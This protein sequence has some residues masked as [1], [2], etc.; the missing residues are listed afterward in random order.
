MPA[1][2]TTYPRRLLRATIL[3]RSAARTSPFAR[4]TRKC[5][6]RPRVVATVCASPVRSRTPRMSACTCLHS[7]PSRPLGHRP[8]FSG[9]SRRGKLISA[10]HTATTL[11]TCPKAAAHGL[12]SG[13][14]VSRE[15]CRSADLLELISHSGSN[16]PNNGEI[17]I[18]EGAL[19]LYPL[20]IRL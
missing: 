1:T 9:I 18:V 4:M 13:K 10:L 3:Y 20:A 6:L 19:D 5:P 17:D 2:E 14:L 8:T 12:R 7:L 11:T 16:W 15:S